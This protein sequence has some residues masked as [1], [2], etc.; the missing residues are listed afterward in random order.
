MDEENLPRSIGSSLV[1]V[2]G[3]S[4]EAVASGR[5]RRGGSRS[6]SG[7]DVGRGR[8]DVGRRGSDVGRRR[9]DGCGSDVGGRGSGSD[10]SRRRRS[11][12]E[13]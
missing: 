10:K 7:R 2:R 6:G 11:G 1:I 13:S 12:S 3:L 9:S 4:S 5:G 8:S